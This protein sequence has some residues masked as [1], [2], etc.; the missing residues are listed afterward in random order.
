MDDSDRADAEV[1]HRLADALR[2]RRPAGPAADGQ[3]HH[4][5]EPVAP[6][7]RWC[8]AYCRDGW[9]RELRRDR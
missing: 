7:L 8:N 2:L 1:E 5:D 4:C 9:E 6:G 3:C